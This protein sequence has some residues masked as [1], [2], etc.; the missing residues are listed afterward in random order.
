MLFTYN[1]I[2]QDG[3]ERSGTIE[4]PSE[5]IAVNALQRRKPYHLL[6]R[7]SGEVTFPFLRD[8]VYQ[9]SE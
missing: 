3:H 1:A 7:V 6:Y 2:D 9:Q 5:D 8:S 4:A